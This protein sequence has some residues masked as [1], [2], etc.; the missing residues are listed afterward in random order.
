MFHVNGIVTY[1]L[2]VSGTSH[3]AQVFEFTVWWSVPTLR[4]FSHCVIFHRELVC[5]A[6][7]PSSHL[8]TDIWVISTS[9]LLCFSLHKFYPPLSTDPPPPTY[10]ELSL[11]FTVYLPEDTRDAGW[12]PGSGRSPGGGNGSPLQNSCQEKFMDR[13]VWQATIC[14]V[15]KVRHDCAHSHTPLWDDAH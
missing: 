9:G 2:L 11:F 13:G 15:A 3:V 10:P 14:G 1:A 4:S 12:I 7:C 6:T 8:L 5:C